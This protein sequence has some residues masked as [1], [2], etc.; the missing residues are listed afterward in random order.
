[1]SCEEIE[2]I[3]FSIVELCVVEG[4]SKLVILVEIQLNRNILINCW[5]FFEDIFGLLT[6]TAKRLKRKC[7]AGFG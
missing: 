7:E 6:N 3:A 4:I 2:L 1:L 5:G